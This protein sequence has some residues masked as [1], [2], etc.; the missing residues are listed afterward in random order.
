[1][2]TRANPRNDSTS[3]GRPAHKSRNVD[4]SL[5]IPSLH[6]PRKQPALEI[7]TPEKSRVMF[8]AQMSTKAKSNG[9]VVVKAIARKGD[10][11]PRTA[12]VRVSVQT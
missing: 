2:A 7:S 9:A 3:L 4:S 10:F 6:V 8:Y 1:M 11:G 5:F 12:L